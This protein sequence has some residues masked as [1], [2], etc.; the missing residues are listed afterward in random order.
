MQCFLQ[1]TMRLFN[2][3]KGDADA[4]ILSGKVYFFIVALFII[5]VVASVYFFITVKYG[6]SYAPISDSLKQQLVV[7]RLTNICFAT[8]N[9]TDPS[10]HQDILDFNKFSKQ[11]V[12]D[13]FQAKYAPSIVVSLKVIDGTMTFQ[14][15]IFYQG[16]LEHKHTRY[17][18]VQ[19]AQGDLH[20]GFLTVK[21]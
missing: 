6:E 11:T 12:E 4:A 20:A 13:C 7:E 10:Y 1:I 17:V 2:N 9:I 19:D 14:D 5:L 16:K 3:K 15:L 21:I 8:K 18:L